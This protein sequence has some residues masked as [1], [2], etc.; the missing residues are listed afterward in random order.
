MPAV[1]LG[2]RSVVARILG[3]LLFSQF[4]T[5]YTTPV[6]YLMFERM[7]RFVNRG[8]KYSALAIEPG[9]EMEEA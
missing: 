8:R 1:R 6:T 5:L 2:V 7:A 9:P 3:G 4:L